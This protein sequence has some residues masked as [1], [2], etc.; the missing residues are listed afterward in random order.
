MTSAWGSRA[1][2]CLAGIAVLASTAAT[3]P[4]GEWYV[5][6]AAGSDANAGTSAASAW[7]T[8]T[9][10]LA[11]LSSLPNDVQTLHVAP[12]TYDPAHG[13]VF[14]LSPPARTRILGTAGSAAT[15]LDGGGAGSVLAY[16]PQAAG[17][18]DAQ[19]GAEGLT[20]RNAVNGLTV[21]AS[22]S[23]S[24]A[25]EFR[26]LRIELAS[27]YG[28]SVSAS[29]AGPFGGGAA[30]RATFDGLFVSHCTQG[31]RAW[32]QGGSLGSA[33]AGVT[34][35]GGVVRECALDGLRHE[36]YGNAATTV[37]VER[38]RVLENGRHGA[39]G[40]VGG[41]ITSAVLRAEGSLFAGN[42]ECGL[43][44]DGASGSEFGLVHLRGCTVA[45]NGTFG[46]RGLN[47][48]LAELHGSILARNP[49]DLDLPPASV[50]ATRSDC[51]DGDLA[52]FAGC[53][54]AD[55]DFVD[56]ASRDYR[57]R[58]GSP[59]A[60]VGDPATIGALDLAGGLRPLDG[61]LDAVAA[62]DMGALELAPLAVT[63][64]PTL[65]GSV[66]LELW[67]ASGAPSALYLARGPL[68]VAPASTA[69][70]ALWLPR[71]DMA[72]VAVVSAR[73]GPP[74][75]LTV[76]MPTNPQWIGRS[77]SFQA[78]TRSSL[79]PRG[80]AFTNPVSLVVLP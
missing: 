33:S 36:A 6:A 62:P 72:L 50:G 78:R 3:A 30:A 65:G 26:D 5:D 16:A 31:V 46:L 28:V 34:I 22:G 43:F 40:S 58:F 48:N 75:T 45:D 70:G 53:I 1:R 25:P 14:P 27:A 60:E 54:A 44:A 74:G 18:V 11:V 80:S 29:S 67:G 61:D 38:L 23:D 17:P 2:R 59:C 41:E 20:L 8:L 71:T 7:R 15:V 24:A 79:A 68:L 56:P 39:Y 10:A 13:E 35:R 55:P 37:T 51:A 9:H 49:D 47:N 63:G 21:G 64:S 66:T 32:A 52:G 76:P 69:F 12:G 77:L 42:G 4:A 73:P 57:L 19:S